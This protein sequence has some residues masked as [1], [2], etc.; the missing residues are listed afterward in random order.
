MSEDRLRA[1]VE[2]G[3][4]INVHGFTSCSPELLRH[5]TRGNILPNTKMNTSM[6]KAFGEMRLMAFGYDLQDALVFVGPTN[7]VIEAT[8]QHSRNDQVKREIR[9]INRI[10]HIRADE[11]REMVA[12]LL[13]LLAVDPKI[14]S[15]WSSHTSLDGEDAPWG[16]QGRLPTAASCVPKIKALDEEE[17]KALANS[18]QWYLKYLKPRIFTGPEPEQ[19]TLSNGTTFYAKGTPCIGENEKWTRHSW[20][21][22]VGDT[23]NLSYNEKVRLLD[24][25]ELFVGCFVVLS[26]DGEDFY[27]ATRKEVDKELAK[28]EIDCE[29]TDKIS[30]S[31][32]PRGTWR[33]VVNERARRLGLGAKATAGAG[34]K[35]KASTATVERKKCRTEL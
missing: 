17:I 4:P 1:K 23:T 12:F 11:W 21:Y 22:F 29:I 32:V 9:K 7:A 10:P 33:R 19:F 35:R 27:Q 26:L 15:W 24:L 28:K 30:R 5:S 6:R 3:R 8:L 20:G 25:R 34:A 2:D 16:Y 14:S 31:A 18:F 13:S